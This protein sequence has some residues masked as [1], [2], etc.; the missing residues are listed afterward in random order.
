MKFNLLPASITLK[1]PLDH[2]GKAQSE[3]KGD[4]RRNPKPKSMF[5]NKVQ[6]SMNP[7]SKT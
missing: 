7:C 1:E 2:W 5:Y 4:G 3:F 6:S